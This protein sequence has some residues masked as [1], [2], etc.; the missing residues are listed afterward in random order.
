MRADLLRSVGRCWIHVGQCELGGDPLLNRLDRWR[1]HHL[2]LGLN[3]SQEP[4]KLCQSSGLRS[5]WRCF[6]AR[7]RRHR[8]LLVKCFEPLEHLRLLKFLRL[9]IRSTLCLLVVSGRFCRFRHL[10]AHS[11]PSGEGRLDHDDAVRYDGFTFPIRGNTQNFESDFLHLVS[12]VRLQCREVSVSLSP[13][14]QDVIFE[15]FH[16]DRATFFALSYQPSCDLQS[17]LFPCFNMRFQRID[18]ESHLSLCLLEQ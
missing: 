1:T 18:D 14:L 5:C 15:H 7:F 12:F 17:C 10:I 9:W 8:R 13:S 2:R 4:I 16:G 6:V 11:F 3:R